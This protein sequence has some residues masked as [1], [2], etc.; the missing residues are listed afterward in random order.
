VAGR[1]GQQ[2]SI[3]GALIDRVVHLRLVQVSDAERFVQ[4]QTKIGYLSR[5]DLPRLLE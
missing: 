1:S 5:S 3:V 4:L 2:T